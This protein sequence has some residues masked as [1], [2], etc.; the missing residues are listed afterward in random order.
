MKVALVHVG[1]VAR[2]KKSQTNY[3]NWS[4]T[5]IKRGFGKPKITFASIFVETVLKWT[6]GWRRMRNLVNLGIWYTILHDIYL[7]LINRKEVYMG[8]S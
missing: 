4:R 6:S 2:L 8:E 5:T 1:R 7:A 3:C